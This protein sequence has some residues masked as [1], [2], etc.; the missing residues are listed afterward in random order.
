M[1][2]LWKDNLTPPEFPRFE[3]NTKTD[4]LVI[5]GGMAGVLCAA[6]LKKS[7]VDCILTEG[8]KSETK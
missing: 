7:G 6:Q 2:Y 3:G 1:N 8:E 4:V 5:G